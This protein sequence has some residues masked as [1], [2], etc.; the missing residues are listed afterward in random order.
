MMMSASRRD[1]LKTAIAAGG[2]AG[3]GALGGWRPY[4]SGSPRPK[5]SLSILILGGTGFIG[6][7]QVRYAL[8]RG[9]TV[10]LFNRGKTK[11]HLFPEL[12]KLVGDRNDRIES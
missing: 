5:K 2:A 12:E 6:P 7:Y 10:T 3:L 4:G 9:H 1:F 8:A 11:P